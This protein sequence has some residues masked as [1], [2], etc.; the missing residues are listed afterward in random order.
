[1][2]IS[3]TRSYFHVDLKTVGNAVVYLKSLLPHK[4]VGELY[5]VLGRAK[6]GKTDRYRSL[7]Q[8]LDKTDDCFFL[9]PGEKGLVMIVFTL[10]QYDIVIKIIRDRFAPPKDISR[11]DVMARYQQVFEHDRAGRL[12][13][14]QEFRYLEFDMDRF[15]L[16]LLEE[17]NSEAKQNILLEKDKI[18]FKHCYIERKLVPLNLYLQQAKRADAERKV[19]DYGQAIRELALSNIF[20][21]DLLLKN[22]GVTIHGRVIFYDYDELCMVTDCNFRDLPIARTDEDEM[23]ADAWFFVAGN[24]IFPEQFISFLGLEPYLRDFFLHWHQEILTAS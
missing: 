13:D 10:Q 8:H 3:Y 17:L 11:K 24:D 2:L 19:Y 1:M 12:A 16:A 6:Q 5:T 7:L 23:R 21:G 4:T 14:A 18:I 9:A 20:P 15:D 22:F